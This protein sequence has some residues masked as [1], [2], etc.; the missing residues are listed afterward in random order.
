MADDSQS[1]ASSGSLVDER[2]DEAAAEMVARIL[3]SVKKKMEERPQ[4]GQLSPGTEQE[5][6]G[7]KTTTTTIT[8]TSVPDSRLSSARTTGSSFSR[9]TTADIRSMSTNVVKTALQSAMQ[10]LTALTADELNWDSA[11]LIIETVVEGWAI[12]DMWKYHVAKEAEGAGYVQAC[13]TWSIPMRRR[14]VPNATAYTMF[15]LNKTEHGISVEWQ[16]EQQRLKHDAT[17]PC[18]EQWLHDVVASKRIVHDAFKI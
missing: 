9:P 2:L 4:S 15:N 12:S 1:E 18:R 11:K 8:T 5:D 17:Q 7:G 10:R 6:A 13:V 14:P 16:L 3:Q